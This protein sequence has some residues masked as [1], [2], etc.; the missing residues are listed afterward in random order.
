MYMYVCMCNVCI[1][2]E[3]KTVDAEGLRVVCTK[4]YTQQNMVNKN[5]VNWNG[6]TAP[7]LKVRVWGNL[8]SLLIQSAAIVVTQ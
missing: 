8:Y 3:K 2:E 7:S 1:Q 4:I 6:G 5:M